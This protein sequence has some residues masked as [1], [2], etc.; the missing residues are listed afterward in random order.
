MVALAV[1]VA[2]AA[3]KPRRIPLPPSSPVVPQIYPVHDLDALPEHFAITG[4]QAIAIAN[5]DK[6]IQKV[7]A[8][9]PTV[10]PLPHLS[11][12]RLAPGAFYHWDIQYRL[13]KKPIAEAEI[14]PRG[15]LYEV[16]T[17]IDVGWPLLKGYS[18][19]LGRALNRPYIWLPLCLI[20][21]LPFFDPRRPFRLLHLDLLV[22]LAFGVSHFYF[23]RGRPDISVPLVYPVLAYLVVRL[24]TATLRPRHRDGPLVPVLPTWAVTAL[25]ALLIAGRIAFGIAGS[26]TFDISF[27]G[28]VGADRIFHGEELY[29]DNEFHPDTYGPVNYLAYVPFERVFPYHPGA[30]KLKA[31]IAATLAF[32]L[33]VLLGL[34]V[35]GRRMIP[36]PAGTRLGLAF[37]LAWAAYP[38]TW[39]L[40]AS[41]TNDALF[42]LF[43]IW[44]LVAINS[45]VARGA[46]L[47]LGTMA[48]FAP[49][50]LLPA[51]GRGLGPFRFKGAVVYTAV[52]LVVAA[53][54]LIPVLPDGG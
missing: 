43:V 53:A 29:T 25:L 11:A 2:R 36:G 41:N 38:Y 6:R 47:G 8:D 22:L 19:V 44:A 48:K 10:K 30:G 28:V 39:L 7:L 9:H 16:T 51:F 15:G 27:A 34:F 20:F 32:D 24:L 4:R 3:D 35:L 54:V 42:P 33:L 52:V 18:G 21:F 14:G 5:R 13:D 45:T 1:Q 12:L 49:A 46:L 31:A 37:A 26:G 40:I 17:G 23:N 50:I